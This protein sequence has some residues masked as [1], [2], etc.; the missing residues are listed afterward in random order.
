V[1]AAAGRLE[2]AIREGRE[3]ADIDVARQEVSELL[4]PLVAR[5]KTALAVERSE[6][7]P[8]APVDPSQARGAASRLAQLLSD[9]DPTAADF[10]DQN[11]GALRSLFEDGAWPTF[12]AL[13]RGYAFDDARAELELITQ[14]RK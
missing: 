4:T 13:V 5:L 14:R 8:I 1:Q 6:P 11:H 7:P 3:R 12:E 2:A 9:F 10:L